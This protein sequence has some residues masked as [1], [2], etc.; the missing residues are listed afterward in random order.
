[1]FICSFADDEPYENVFR[2]ADIIGDLYHI[3]VTGNYKK[4]SIDP[5]VIP[6]NVTLLGYIS[7]TEYV[8][9][10]HSVDITI[11]LT[12]RENCLLCGAY[13]SVAAEKPMIISNTKALREYFDKGAIYTDNTAHDITLSIKKAQKEYVRVEKRDKKLKLKNKVNG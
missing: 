13:E 5:R 1:M 8:K 10:I 2:A 6:R 4:K 12:D 3:Y 11:D 7:E 9:M